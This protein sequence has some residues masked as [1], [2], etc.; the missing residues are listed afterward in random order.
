MDRLKRRTNFLEE[1]YN[2]A[3]PSDNTRVAS[4]YRAAE[5]IRTILRQNRNVD[6][7]LHNIF[8]EE[9]KRERRKKYLEEDKARRA[10]NAEYYTNKQQHDHD[11]FL[12]Y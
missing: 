9:E 12:E 10:F 11:I 3:L 8:K 4:P 7:E 5:K 1:K 6:E 2:T